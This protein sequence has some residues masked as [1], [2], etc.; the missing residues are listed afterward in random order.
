MTQARSALERVV[1]IMDRLRSPGGCPW[2]A[3]Q[4]HQS[5]A[6]YAIEEAYE[7]AEA[8]ESGDREHLREELGDVLLQVLFHAR[9]ASESDD[10]FDID[11]VAQ[12]LID[13]LVRRHPHVFG[14][15]GEELTPGEVNARWDA[16]KSAEKQRAHV[17]DGIPAALPA[18]A[19]AQKV[20]G[21]LDRAGIDGGLDGWFDVGSGGG[22]GAATGTDGTGA[23]QA[24][25]AVG[26]QL[27][28]LVAQ[29]RES[30]V[31]AEAALRAA[32]RDLEA[33]VRPASS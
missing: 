26:A 27:L 20:L 4:T 24:S 32:V 29:A 30:G 12:G 28:Q 2:D 33:R 21:R 17:L 10:G 1:E 18:L 16:L 22:I 5:L 19:R 15:V 6:P 14:Q 31:D 25:E 13:K 11:D 3:E 23:D 8:A 7:L 9:I